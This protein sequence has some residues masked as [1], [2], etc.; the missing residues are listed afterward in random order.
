MKNPLAALAAALIL[1]APLAAGA[2]EVPSYA[3]SDAQDQQIRGRVENFDGGYNLQV[4][5]DQGYVDNVEFHDGT[6]INPTGLTIAPGMVV[7][8][9]GYNAGSYFAANE[10]DT[11]YAFDAGVP[12]Y[13]GHPWSYYG[14]SIDLNFFFGNTGWWHG[15][16]FG[17]DYRY[18]RGVRTYNDA[19][20]RENVRDTSRDHAYIDYGHAVNTPNRPTQ[21]ATQPQ[22]NN[23][24][25]RAEGG[26]PRAWAPAPVSRGGEARGN[27]GGGSHGGGGGEH[28]R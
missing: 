15:T 9:L 24:F 1:A 8:I 25:A 10:V 20:V 23:G 11:P 21:F 7:S 16:D 12:Y 22:R 14:P 19:R 3:A 4:R 27:G 13:G 6:I 18:D 26:A 5:D 17:G 2:Q 28:R